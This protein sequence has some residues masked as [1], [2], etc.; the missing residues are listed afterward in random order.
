MVGR[1]AGTGNPKPVN[2]VKEIMPQDKVL[3]NPFTGM[4]YFNA[5]NAAKEQGVIELVSA[6]DDDD[7]I[8]FYLIFY[9]ENDDGTFSPYGLEITDSPTTDTFDAD[10]LNAVRSGVFMARLK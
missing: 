7:Y 5:A 6:P 4:P 3:R 10:A 2:V 8:N 9:V 1:N